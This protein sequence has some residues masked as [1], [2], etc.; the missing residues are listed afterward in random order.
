MV[1]L[2]GFHFFEERSYPL[3]RGTCARLD[4]ERLCSTAH[5]RLPGCLRAGSVQLSQEGWNAIGEDSQ[6]PLR[7]ERVERDRMHRIAGE[8]AIGKRPQRDQCLLILVLM[9]R[10]VGKPLCTVAPLGVD[11]REPSSALAEMHGQLVS[12][13]LGNDKQRFGLTSPT[14]HLP[15]RAGATMKLLKSSLQIREARCGELVVLLRAPQLAAPC[16]A[17]LLGRGPR[18]RG[19]T[20]GRLRGLE[21]LSTPRDI[22]CGH[23]RS[24]QVREPVLRPEKGGLTVRAPSLGRHEVPDHTRQGGIRFVKGGSRH[25]PLRFRFGDPALELVGPL[26]RGEKRGREHRLPRFE[27]TTYFPLEAL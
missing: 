9:G 10:G 20:L 3:A 21:L 23:K 25:I 18:L 22:R 11:L 6:F 17:R 27:H 8:F 5:D 26:A 4:T 15:V 1:P 14:H 19:L 24:P 12:S 16:L 7:A 13:K 2:L